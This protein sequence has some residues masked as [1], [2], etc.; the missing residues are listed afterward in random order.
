MDF[1]DPRRR[2][3]HDADKAIRQLLKPLFALFEADR[4][5]TEVNVNGPENVFVTR[6]GRRESIAVG[7]D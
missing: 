1:I 6:N 3:E 4:A 7:A 5:V 2:I